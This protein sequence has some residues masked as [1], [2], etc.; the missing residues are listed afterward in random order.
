MSRTFAYCR[1]STTGQTTANQ[2]REIEAAGFKVE[3]RRIVEETVSG[4]SA[5]E[6]RPGFMKLLDRLEH[7]DCLVVTK[8]DRLGRNAV[9]ILS[10]VAELEANG[11]RVHCIALGGVDLTSAAGKMMMTVVAAMAAFEKDLLLE[12][13][14]AGLERAW[15]AGKVSGRRAILTDA[16]RADV[17][18]KLAKGASVAALA[19]E[20][21]TSRMTVMRA[22][23]GATPELDRD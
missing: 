16:Q 7:G 1:V 6:Q 21:R 12:R 11:V 8:L 10:T 22:R 2:I 20:L 9:D 17:R 18:A 15:A 3:P 5:I 4:S 14:Q 23:D 13:T 19:R